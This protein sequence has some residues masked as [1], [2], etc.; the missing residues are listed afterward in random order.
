MRLNKK[1]F[2]VIIGHS[3]WGNDSYESEEYKDICSDACA[4]KEFNRYIHGSSDTKYI[5]FEQE[6]YDE[7]D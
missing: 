1:Y 2:T 7:N 3:D 6:T 4:S 5:K